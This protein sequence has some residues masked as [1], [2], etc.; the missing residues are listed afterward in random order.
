MLTG[1]QIT[2]KLVNV[3][4]VLVGNIGIT[5]LLLILMVHLKLLQILLVFSRTP[6]KHNVPFSSTLWLDCFLK[7]AVKF[8]NPSVSSFLLSSLWFWREDHLANSMSV[9]AGKYSLVLSLVSDAYF[10]F[11]LV[12]FKTRLLWCHFLFSLNDSECEWHLTEEHQWQLSKN[13]N[14]HLATGEKNSLAYPELSSEKVAG[15]AQP[16]VL[17]ADQWCICCCAWPNQ[18]GLCEGLENSSLK[19]GKPWEYWNG[20]I[21]ATGGV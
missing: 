4:T 18:P 3:S 19:L 2:R 12:S 1:L 9:H 13:E 7:L 5:G 6:L 17:L 11:N 20:V 16:A 15:R 8:I 10:I 21:K 14:L